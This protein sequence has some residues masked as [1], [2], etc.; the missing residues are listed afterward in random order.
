MNSLFKIKLRPS[1]KKTVEDT[2]KQNQKEARTQGTTKREAA[3]L[4]ILE[5]ARDKTAGDSQICSPKPGRDQTQ[6]YLC[7]FW[8]CDSTPIIIGTAKKGKWSA[9]PCVPTGVEWTSVKLHHITL[10]IRPSQRDRLHAELIEDK[11]WQ[12]DLWLRPELLFWYT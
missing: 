11:V 12:W 9:R 3:Y 4:N 10:Q 8:Q 2:W 6:Q 7:V 1:Q 5:M